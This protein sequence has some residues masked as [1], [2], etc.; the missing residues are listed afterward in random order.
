MAVDK[1]DQLEIGS[2]KYDI[3]LPPDAEV[4][5][6]S[7]N[8]SSSIKVNGTD[9]LTAHQSIKTLDTTATSAQSTSD[10]ETIAGSGKI[11]LHKVSKTG[12]YNDLSNKPT[13]LP[14]NGG[15]SDTVDN[16]HAEQL[17]VYAKYKYH[18]IAAFCNAAVPVYEVSADGSTGWTE[19]T[20]N[21]DIFAAKENFSF[22]VTNTSQ[23][24]ARFTWKAGIVW[25][26]INY[27]IIGWTY[28]ATPA[29]VTLKFES[30]ADSG[31]TW[32][33]RGT[34]TGIKLNSTPALYN[35]S[36]PGGDTWFRVSIIQTSETGSKNISTIK[37]LT[38]RWGDQGLGSEYEKPYVSDGDKTVRPWTHGTQLLGTSSCKWKEIHGITIYENGTALTNK[39]LGKSAKA[40]DSDKLDGNDSAYYQKALPT[41]TTAGK[42]LKSTTTAGTV[43]WADDTNTTYTIASGDSNGQIKVTPSSGT[44][45]NVDVKGLGAA[46]YKA[47][48]TSVTSGSS[49]LITSG[50]VYTAI[51]NL[52]EPMV[53]KGTLGT[54]GTITT[55]PTAS[56]S[57]GYTYKVITA[58]TYASQSA[59]VGDVFVSNGSAWVL[60]PAGD[61]VEDTWRNIKVNDNELLGTGISSGAVNFKNGGNITVTGSGNNITL[62][63]ASG[64]SIPSTT[65]QTAWSAKYDKPSGGIPDSDLASTFVKK[66]NNS[67]P[68]SNGNVLVTNL[69]PICA[70]G[71]DS[72]NTA[73]WYK[74]ATSTL[75]GWGNQNILYF[76]KGGYSNGYS[77]ILNLEMRSDNTAVRCWKCCWVA[78]HPNLTE[79]SVIIVIDGMTWT[80]YAYNTSSQYGRLYFTEI[81]NRSIN[82]GSPTWS[83]TYFNSNT[84]EATE[85]TATAT[86]SDGFIVA[87]AKEDK[88][89]NAI[90]TTYLK[91]H[92]SIKTL[93][94]DNT[95][96]Q[97]ASSSEALNGSGTINL[98]KIAK[99]GTYGDLIGTPIPGDSGEI[100]TKYRI[101]L[102]GYTG[103]GNP[104]WYYKL[105]KLPADNSGNYASAIINGRIGGWTAGGMSSIYCL[106][107]NRDGVGLA[108][109]DIGG[110]GTMSS[111]FDI[112]D[113]VVYKNS[114]NTADIYIRCKGYFTFD[115]DVEVYQ[116]TASITYDGTYTTT[117][118]S[119]TESGKASTSTS[120]LQLEKGVL[121][122]NGT[123]V[124]LS[125]HD[126]D[127]VYVKYSAAQSL[128][129]AQK[130]QARSNIGAIDSSALGDQVTYSY[131]AGVLTITSK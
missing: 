41:T 53:F 26:S 70:V 122:V 17:L 78:R 74:I 123:A 131:S 109:L 124:S 57:E 66:V 64:Y 81:S 102:K 47:V 117:T 22:Q 79:G 125:T 121:K 90:D 6:K 30:S 56:S 113:L 21:K 103:S 120:R 108:L 10:S 29:T 76:V 20:L 4:S 77:G 127:S 11:T 52:P 96:A 54:G 1:I 80:M 119:G 94:T 86:S 25:S 13:S 99:T 7:V 48:D 104:I 116:S 93:K 75:S 31:S 32:T 67:T 61:D 33:D 129:A 97:T 18:D 84:P 130:T 15:N 107:W 27:A 3:D 28:Q 63:V 12:N 43:E 62:G 105:I 14:A 71:S 87:R 8:A 92:Q 60:I 36:S 58:G 100:K 24:G 50:A 39:Y 35:F 65:N 40:A 9:V 91:S 19:T 37:L 115:L 46:A 5:I 126:H 16:Y 110:T 69:V 111:I 55:L 42:V 68:D 45:Y 95:T 85:P 101:A 82:G 23:M 72:A 88:D 44:A 59:K 106:I 34:T 49:N 114:D 112:A 38:S 83:I 51:N 98:H 73:G 2:T 118:P 89:G 128:T